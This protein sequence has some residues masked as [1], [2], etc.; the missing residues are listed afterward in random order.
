MS[1]SDSQPSGN[2]GNSEGNCDH[3]SFDGEEKDR[4]N[5]TPDVNSSD[6]GE[7]IEN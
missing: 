6:E 3:E 4:N 7:K 2:K 1:S 5:E